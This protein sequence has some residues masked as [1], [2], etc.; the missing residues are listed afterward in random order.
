MNKP[1]VNMI[2]QRTFLGSFRYLVFEKTA[3]DPPPRRPTGVAALSLWGAWGH[4]PPS[5]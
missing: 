4:Q 5:M 3:I 2:A 1:A